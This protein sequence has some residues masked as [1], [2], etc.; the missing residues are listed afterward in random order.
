MAPRFR[1]AIAVVG[2][3]G[4]ASAAPAGT[5]NFR[6]VTTTQ[7][8]STTVETAN[9]E[10]AVDFGDFDQDGDLDVLIGNAYSDFGSRRNKLY[11]NDGGIMVEVTGAPIIPGFDILR[12]TRV[13]FLRDYTGDGWLDIA[14]INDQN[15]H[16]NDLHINVQVDGVFDHFENVG[17]S[18]FP[19]GGNGGSANGGVSLDV[20]GVNGADLII[21]N[22]RN[23]PQ[24]RLWLNDGTG[25]FIDATV[26]QMPSDGS[27][28]TVDL[29]TGDLNGDGQVDLLTSNHN[30]VNKVYYNN[31]PG[32]TSTGLGDFLYTPSGVQFLLDGEAN[33]NSMETGDFNNDDRVDI[34]WSG[35]VGGLSVDRVFENMGIDASGKA[36]LELLPQ[37]LL[38]GSVTTIV[39][40]K[41]TVADLNDDGRLDIFVPKEG[42]T[43][44]RPTIL[45][46][47]TVNG[48]TQFIDWT[49]GKAFPDGNVHKGWHAAVFDAKGRVVSGPPPAPLPVYAVKE[50]SGKVYVSAG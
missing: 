29:A 22:G 16:P 27:D 13:A 14:V 10:K 43:Q 18:R 28:Y 32:T 46:N 12:V 45:R 40:R 11:R 7:V 39:S 47:V 50:V 9:N 35:G 3:L 31:L 23:N 37:E 8:M 15:S 26:D 20:D 21:V 4:A 5:L 17:Q 1:V 19:A 49:P 38:P 41:V 48:V 24:S 42:G 44:S 34:Y 33:E 25:F 36:I 2:L 6:D 30:V